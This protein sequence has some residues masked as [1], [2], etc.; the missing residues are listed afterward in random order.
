MEGQHKF[1][2]KGCNTYGTRDT[3]DQERTNKRATVERLALE[4]LQS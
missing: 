3:K 4:R 2:C 1:H